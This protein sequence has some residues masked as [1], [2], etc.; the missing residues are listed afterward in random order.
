MEKSFVC[1]VAEVLSPQKNLGQRIANLQ[2]TNY[3]LQITNTVCKSQKRLSS[4]RIEKIRNRSAV[5][6]DELIARKEIYLCRV[7]CGQF[8]TLVLTRFHVAFLPFI[9]YG[10]NTYA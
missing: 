2:I 8:F 10:N 9:L 5:G 3:K 7:S 6:K 1:G 4:E